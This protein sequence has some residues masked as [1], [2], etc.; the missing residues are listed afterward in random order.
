MR[1]FLWLFVFLICPIGCNK[2]PSQ[3]PDTANQTETNTVK[4]KVSN[5]KQQTLHWIIEQPGTVEPLEV[6]P[7]VVKLSGYIKSI[8]PDTSARKAGIKL[9]GGQ[10]TVIDIG[11]EVE[12]GQLLATLDIPELEAELVEK[13]SLF[14]RAKVE[15]AQTEKEF[16][17]AESQVVTASSM[18]TEAE[19]G[20]VRAETD[21]VRWKAE[22]DQVNT[23]IAGGVG[24]TQT[25]NVVTKSWDAA[26]AAKLEAEA[27]VA[28]AKALVL[29][30]KA[31]KE[32]AAADVDT[33]Q[34]RV[35]VASAE[36]ERVKALVGYMQ[37]TSPFPGIITARN[38]HTK[39]FMQPL[40]GNQNPVLFTVARVDVLR[41]FVDVP[42]DSS[43]KA[44]PGTVAVIRVPSL[45]GR[46]YAATVTRTTRVLNPNSRTLRVEIDID[47]ADRALKPGSYVVAK[48]LATSSNAMLIPTGCVLAADETHY[49]YLVEGG[50][51]IKYRVQ[52]GHADNGMI[53]VHGKRK[54]SSTA[55]SWEKLTGSEQVIDG[56]LGA[57]ADGISVKLE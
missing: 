3:A 16:L 17:V 22:L 34:A 12:E 41:V 43:D 6:T 44:D 29:E 52:L 51:A 7:V 35:E 11:S 1:P 48:L 4:V 24:D 30:R 20:V 25:R 45:A 21:V 46:E 42:E 13:K 39:H 53:Q 50:K 23:Q 37:I 10:P 40:A 9:P 38:V 14:G 28:T 18:V 55:G 57:L 32:R 36:V 33:A 19:A 56:N 31:R 15:K 2:T 49:V 8:A 27:K 47:N 54:A 5:P 26:K